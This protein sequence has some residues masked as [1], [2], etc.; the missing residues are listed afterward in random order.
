MLRL[1]CA[2][3]SVISAFGGAESSF[4]PSAVVTVEKSPARKVFGSISLPLGSVFCNGRP[5][6]WL[7]GHSIEEAPYCLNV[8]DDR[9]DFANYDY[10]GSSWVQNSPAIMDTNDAKNIV[11]GPRN[12]DRHDCT[13][14]DA[15]LDGTPD[16]VCG[17]GANKGVRT[18]T[19]RIVHFA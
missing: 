13:L 19:G 11:D 6:Y 18:S 3:L 10:S 15:N 7:V 9:L 1:F 5:T 16:I 4:Q 2:A 12:L 17:V 14:V 8:T